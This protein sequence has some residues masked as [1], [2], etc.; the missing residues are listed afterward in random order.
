[1]HHLLS[2]LRTIQQKGMS[3][4]VDKKGEEQSW[5]R[6]DQGSGSFSHFVIWVIW[7]PVVLSHFCILA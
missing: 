5:M 7:Q 4:F 2:H 1:M 6:S 3:C